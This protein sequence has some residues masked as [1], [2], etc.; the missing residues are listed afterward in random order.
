MQRVVLAMLAAVSILLSSCANPPEASRKTASAPKPPPEPPK[1][2]DFSEGGV[3]A[4]FLPDGRSMSLLRDFSFTD[5]DGYVWTARV[6]DQFN[7]AS[8]PRVF[9]GVTGGPFDGQFR[10]AAVIHDS[11]CEHPLRHLPRTHKQAH[12]AFYEGMIKRKVPEPTAQL[13]YAAVYASG[14]CRWYDDGKKQKPGVVMTDK[15]VKGVKFLVDSKRSMKAT[16]F[17]DLL[18]SLEHSFSKLR[19][20]LGTLKRTEP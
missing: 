6:K 1:R 8:I 11:A 3:Q 18:D 16:K 13:M 14:H 17:E 19:D 9:W 5:S 2:R 10:D 15:F 20:R 7:G 12:R 4:E